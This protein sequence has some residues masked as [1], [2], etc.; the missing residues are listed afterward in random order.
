LD[1]AREKGYKDAEDILEWHFK[2]EELWRNRNCLIKLYMN[3]EKT[4]FKN[5]SLG[6]F[7]EIIKYA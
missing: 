6:I 7:R 3:K 5:L 4:V 1:I 2:R